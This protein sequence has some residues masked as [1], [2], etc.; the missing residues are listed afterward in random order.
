MVRGVGSGDGDGGRLEV[1]V[2][3]YRVASLEDLELTVDCAL[4][5]HHHSVLLLDTA[6]SPDLSL[7]PSDLKLHPGRDCGVGG[8]TLSGTGYARRSL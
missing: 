8:G 2:S 5:H 6:V 7:H 4:S 1:G 3:R